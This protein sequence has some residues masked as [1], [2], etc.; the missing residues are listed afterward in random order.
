MLAA[1]HT[2]SCQTRSG[3][4]GMQ[5]GRQ[6]MRNA[7]YFVCFWEDDLSIALETKKPRPEIDG[8][9]PLAQS[10]RKRLHKARPQIY[11]ALA[12]AAAQALGPDFRVEVLD[13][14][15]RVIARS[16]GKD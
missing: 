1:T 4:V 8:P 5:A 15:Q 13:Y 7:D 2:F 10:L 3:G 11:K 14:R 9:D 12:R 16:A 6:K